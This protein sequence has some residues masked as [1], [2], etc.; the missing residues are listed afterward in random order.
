[1]EHGS[2]VLA[3]LW[4][5]VAQYWPYCGV[6]YLSDGPTVECGISVMALLW[7]MVAQC[8]PYCGVW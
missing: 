2:S 8:W 5:V 6:W 7:S 4:S 1:M 3:L